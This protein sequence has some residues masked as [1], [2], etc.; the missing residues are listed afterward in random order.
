MQLVSEFL[1]ICSSVLVELSSMLIFINSVL[2]SVCKY[3][4]VFVIVDDFELE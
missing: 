4:T 1:N 2:A 3:K